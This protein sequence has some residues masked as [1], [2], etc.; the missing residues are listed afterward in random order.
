[1][2]CDPP[3][4]QERMSLRS[5]MDFVSLTKDADP[6][7]GGITQAARA[8]FAARGDDVVQALKIA[9]TK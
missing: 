9:T 6:S 2:I 4:G 3:K 1:M 5:F 7:L 8:M